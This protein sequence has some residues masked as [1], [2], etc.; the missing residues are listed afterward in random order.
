MIIY[1]AVLAFLL[2]FMYFIEREKKGFS[3]FSFKE[4]YNKIIILGSLGLIPVLAVQLF[5][6]KTPKDKG[7][8]YAKL[9]SGDNG[10]QKTHIKLAGL[11]YKCE[12]DP[13]YANFVELFHE[14]SVSKF[15]D[16]CE[17]LEDFTS[18]QNLDKDRRI[19]LNGII[20]I[21]CWNHPLSETDLI[22][23]NQNQPGLNYTKGLNFYYQGAYDSAEVYFYK[24]VHYPDLKKSSYTYLERIARESPTKLKKLYLNWDAI[25][26]L[27]Q[28]PKQQYYFDNGYFAHYTFAIYNDFYRNAEWLTIIIAFLVCMVWI[29]YI[30]SIDIFERES[31]INVFFVFILS[32]L[33]TNLCFYSYD[34][35][36]YKLDWYLSYDSAFND[37]MYC[38]IVIGGSEE[39][40]KLLPWTL[41]ILI[42][43]KAANEPYDYLLYACISALGFAG[44]ENVMYYEKHAMSIIS[45]RAIMSSVGHMFDASLIAYSVILMKYRF[46]DKNWRYFLPVGGFVAACLAH[47]FYDY[48][49]ISPPIPGM[50]VITLI[51]FIISIHIWKN[52]KNN[53]LNQSTFYSYKKR[54]T[55]NKVSY[56]L[57]AGFILILMIEYVVT[58]YQ[59][60]HKNS[61]NILRSSSLFMVFFGVYLITTF[62]DFKLR[63]GKWAKIKWPFQDRFLSLLG[64]KSRNDI[65]GLRLRLFSP[66]DNPYVGQQ[67]PITGYLSQEILIDDKDG[68]Y[69]FEIDQSVLVSGFESKQIVIRSKNKEYDLEDERIEIILLLIPLH[70]DVNLPSLRTDDFRYVGRTYSSPI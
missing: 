30:W 52:M 20:K 63:K 47:G 70:V 59:L 18:R 45:M 15:L 51:F 65:A 10:A 8:F 25:K 23:E 55:R 40:I 34:F 11:R 29:F 28:M 53:A 56:I 44:A 64:M 66:K 49:L 5:V 57:L 60:G 19:I 54:L 37:F 9:S 46:Q 68:W 32:W 36:H 48:W 2:L 17:G 1:L 16:K 12:Q 27:P 4:K 61:S 21:I 31:W 67:F 14:Q 24:E 3:R 69:V 42:N 58:S 7:A 38:T 50:R 39:L 43:R 6:P 33:A 13:S 35:F 62:E 22:V 26:Y 41:F